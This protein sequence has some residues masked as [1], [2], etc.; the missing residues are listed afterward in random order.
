MTAQEAA[1]NTYRQQQNA[2]EEVRAGAEVEYQYDPHE[3][4]LDRMQD[5]EPEPELMKA[6]RRRMR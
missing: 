3:L 2:L 5:S 4:K 6:C 1:I